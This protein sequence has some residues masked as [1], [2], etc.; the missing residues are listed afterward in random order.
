LFLPGKRQPEQ[1]KLVMKTRIFAGL[2]SSVLLACLWMER[3]AIAT[4]AGCVEVPAA[5]VAAQQADAVLGIMS[6]MDSSAPE[7]EVPVLLLNLSLDKELP[8][9]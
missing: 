9:K 6:S 5:P 7:G 8:K 2:I 4:A 1:E 3:S